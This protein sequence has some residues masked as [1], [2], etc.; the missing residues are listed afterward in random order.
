MLVHLVIPVMGT[1]FPVLG[2]KL[3]TLLSRTVNYNFSGRTYVYGTVDTVC[4]I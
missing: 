4:N 2:H 1:G 3:L